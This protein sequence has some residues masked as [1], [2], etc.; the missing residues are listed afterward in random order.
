MPLLDL[1][2]SPDRIYGGTAQADRLYA[3]P[4]L[5]WEAPVV[6]AGG[7]ADQ[8]FPVDEEIAPLNIAAD[9]TGPNIVYTLA[10]SSDPLPESLAIVDGVLLGVP[11]EAAVRTIVVRGANSANFADST[12]Q[13]TAVAG[14]IIS[15]L[16][17]NGG[18]ISFDTTGANGTVY[19]AFNDNPSASKNSIIAGTGDVAANFAVTGSGGQATN[20]DVSSLAGLTRWLHVLHVA[21]DTGRSN[22]LRRE[23]AVAAAT[24]PAAFTSGQWTASTG[25]GASEIDIN[26]IALPNDGG[27][28][29]TALQ[30]STDAGATWVNLT[31]TGTGL[32]T[33]DQDSDG[34][35]GTLTAATSYDIEVR[36]VNAVGNGLDSDTKVRT[37]G[38]AAP[39][40]IGT[41][42][43]LLATP[44]KDSAEASATHTTATVTPTGG[45][46]VVIVVHM[47]AGVTTAETPSATTFGGV[48][49]TPH[50]TITNNARV[51]TFIYVVDN[52]A[53]SAQAFSITLP[54]TP[55]GI[56][57]EVLEVPGAATTATVGNIMTAAAGSG[58]A[59][60]AVSGTTGTNGS[61]VLYAVSKRYSAETITPSGV[62][63]NFTQ[64]DSGDTNVF[65]DVST[66]IAWEVVATA[67]AAAATFSW[68][69]ADEYAAVGLELKAA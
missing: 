64:Q 37:S 4:T 59:S 67:G 36:A 65:R 39:S 61:L 13:I 48:D 22:V 15:N 69:T 7:L 66:M 50:E 10:P 49:I 68:T 18:D 23:V 42:V 14:P 32:R 38:A 63:G 1:N 57:I 17:A 3:G 21:A 62:D 45:R 35:T 6:A 31:G 30:Y 26:I 51:H 12:F 16:V 2:P 44:Y 60:V 43:R 28:A 25:S 55:R 27:S 20:V 47:Q 53:T 58:A 33:I 56:V 5:A 52:P 41:P 11:E 40:G 29:I 24:A 19:V 8:V 54:S 46:P 9:F 34:T